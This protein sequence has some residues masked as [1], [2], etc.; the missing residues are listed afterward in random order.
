MHI[1]RHVTPT[2]ATRR[3]RTIPF[4]PGAKLPALRQLQEGELEQLPTINDVCTYWPPNPAYDPKRVL[5]RRMFFINEDKTKYVSN[6]YYTARDYQPLVDFDAIRWGGSE[7]LILAVE[8]VAS[9][10]NSMCVGGDRVVIKCESGNFRV[11]TPRGHGSARPFVATEYLSLT[12]PDM[13]YPVRIFHILQQICANILAQCRTVVL[14]V[15]VLSLV[16]IC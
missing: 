14:C 10:R 13:D 7:C 12:Q 1:A 16:Y 5:L 11:H 2:M 15:I 4:V 9:I 8:N 3:R 6:S